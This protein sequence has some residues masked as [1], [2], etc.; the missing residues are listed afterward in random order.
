MVQQDEDWLYAC[1]VYKE[2][3][4]L[5]LWKF[6]WFVVFVFML[7]KLCRQWPQHRDGLFSSSS[8]SRYIISYV[9]ISLV[10]PKANFFMYTHIYTPR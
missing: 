5:G 4:E 1:A 10:A 9:I 6:S 7:L 2:K 8:S 3:I